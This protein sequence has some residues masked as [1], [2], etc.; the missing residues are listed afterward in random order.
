MGEAQPRIMIVDDEPSIRDSLQMFLTDYDYLVDTAASAEEAEALLGQQQ[1]QIALVDVRL[2]GSSGN[3][4]ILT[5][6]QHQPQLKFL[7]HT[8][9]IN[10]ELPDALAEIGLGQEHILLKPQPSMAVLRDKID[11][12]LAEG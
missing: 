5:A 6:H 8:G 9:S 10:Y 3:A 2:A 4:F 1:Y 12:L 11:G 7:I